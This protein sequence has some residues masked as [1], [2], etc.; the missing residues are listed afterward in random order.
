MYVHLYAAEYG[1]IE[2]WTWSVEREKSPLHYFAYPPSDP[3][4]SMKISSL[5]TERRICR[6]RIINHTWNICLETPFCRAADPK[7]DNGC[8]VP[9]TRILAITILSTWA[10]FSKQLYCVW[11]WN[12]VDGVWSMGYSLDYRRQQTEGLSNG[13]LNATR[14]RRSFRAF[15]RLWPIRPTDLISSTRLKRR[16]VERSKLSQRSDRQLTKYNLRN[17]FSCIRSRR[18]TLFTR[19]KMTE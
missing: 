18:S 14:G 17:C 7:N 19:I 4:R 6:Q 9:A 5:L 12:R 8:V 1:Q 15:K 16:A 2:F 3:S 13:P 11:A 10:A